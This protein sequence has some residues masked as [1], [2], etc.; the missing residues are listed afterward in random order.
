[1]T[2]QTVQKNSQTFAEP[3][4]SAC[5]LRGRGGDFYTHSAR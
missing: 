2:T 4:L 5:V 3:L 1:M